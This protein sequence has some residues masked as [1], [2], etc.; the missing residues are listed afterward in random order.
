MLANILT[1]RAKSSIW[2]I[3]FLLKSDVTFGAPK[4]RKFWPSGYFQ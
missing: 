4:G 3:Y 2:Y 1:T